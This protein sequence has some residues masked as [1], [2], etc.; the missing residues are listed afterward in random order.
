VTSTV[1]TDSA[2]GCTVRAG[3]ASHIG[4]F[5]ENNEDRVYLDPKYPFALVLDGMGGL[6]AGEVASRNGETALAHA[7]RKGLRAGAEPPGLIEEAL[8]TGNEAVRTLGQI[9][10]NLRNCGTTVVLALWHCDR[11]YVSW[12]GDSPAFL[13]SGGH[14]K[15]LTWEHDLRTAL[16]RHGIIGAADAHD[17]RLDNVLWRYLGA[18][19]S[20]EPIEVPSFTPRRGDRLVLATDGVTGV[21]PEPLLMEICRAHPDPQICADALVATALE[22]GSRDNCTCAVIAF[23]DDVAPPHPARKWWHFWR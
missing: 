18:E 7:L 4:Y 6:A 11:V 2:F 22:R 5:R 3:A 21:T 19:E 14:V 10:R 9:D 13:V 20:K 12:L 8:R 17:Y 23:G 16:V 1:W 15:K